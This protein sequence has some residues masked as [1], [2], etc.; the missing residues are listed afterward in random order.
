[1][2][3]ATPQMWQADEVP[4]G[5]V[6]ARKSEGADP[7]HARVRHA[8]RLP[9]ACLLVMDADNA[10]R[11]PSAS[12][13]MTLH[14]AKGLEFDVVFLPGWEEGLFPHQ[15]SLDESR[16][17]R[18]RRGAPARLCRAHPRAAPGQDQLRPEP[19]QARHVA[20]GDPSR[21]IDELPEAHVEVAERTYGGLAHR[22]LRAQPLRRAPRRLFASGFYETPGWQRAKRNRPPGGTPLTTGARADHHRRH[23]RRCEHGE[24]AGLS[25]G[26]R[27][28]HQKF[29]YGRIAAGRRQQAHRRFRQGRAE[30]GGGQLRRALLSEH[31]CTSLL[32]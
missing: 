9:R 3:P 26:M 24:G 29:G 14:A 5:A 19:P 31:S 2:S 23:A 11:G 7:L 6:E 16:P 30:E 17:L 8:G 1:M 21:F 27:V 28:F 12:I 10:K 20:A 25:V 15:R 18:A 13:L 22:Q 4:A 32:L